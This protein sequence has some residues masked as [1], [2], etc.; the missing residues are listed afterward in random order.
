MPLL[1]L[2]IRVR[3]AFSS[4]EEWIQDLRRLHPPRYRQKRRRRRTTIRASP[5][6]VTRFCHAP[7]PSCPSNQSNEKGQ[8]DYWK[9]FLSKFRNLKRPTENVTEIR[10]RIQES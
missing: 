9:C 6:K 2:K 7:I 5:T 10:N 4:R 3:F 8:R 1:E